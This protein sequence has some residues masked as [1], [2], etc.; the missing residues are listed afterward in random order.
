MEY[1]WWG[2][3]G[4]TPAKW[5]SK[6]KTSFFFPVFITSYLS[7]KD[8]RMVTLYAKVSIAKLIQM[9]PLCCIFFCYYGYA[10]GREEL[11]KVDW[12]C[13]HVGAYSA[14]FL[15]ASRDGGEWRCSYLRVSL[16]E[17][18][19]LSPEL[20]AQRQGFPR[21]PLRFL[22]VAWVSLTYAYAT[23]KAPFSASLPWMVTNEA[24][25]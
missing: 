13:L 9:S 17:K 4:I 21:G 6:R 3:W 19:P 15:I 10:R 16:T 23:A 5:K 2:G 12:P 24:I 11:C 1:G 22:N 20:T 7:F 25:L 8:I 14:N 18:S